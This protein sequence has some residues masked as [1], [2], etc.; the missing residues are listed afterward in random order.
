LIK[1]LEISIVLVV[2]S[3]LYMW[4]KFVLKRSIMERPENTK[5]FSTGS[6]T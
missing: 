6:E 4:Q 2:E 1:K 5:Y 3:E